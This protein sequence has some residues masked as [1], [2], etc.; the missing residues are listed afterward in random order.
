MAFHWGFSTI[1]GS[2]FLHPVLNCHMSKWMSFFTCFL[3]AFYIPRAATN[4][5]RPA[6]FSPSDSTALYRLLGLPVEKVGSETGVYT[7][8]NGGQSLAARLWLFEHAQTSINIQYYSLTKDV[9]GRLA[10][11]YLVR[12]ADRGVL[13]RIL[14]DDA[15]NRMKNFDMQLLNSHKNIE[16]RVYNAGFKAG[17]IDKKLTRLGKNVDRML[18]RM[19]NKTLT[20][21]GSVC[22]MGGRNIADRY[23]DYDLKYNFRDRDVVFFGKAVREVQHSFDQFWNSKLTVPYEELSS[24]KNKK[25]LA[26][27]ARFNCMHNFPKKMK[28]LAAMITKNAEN[29]PQDVKAWLA[30]DTVVFTPNVTFISDVPGKNEDRDRQGGVCTDS[31]ISLI[32]HARRSLDIQTPYFIITQEARQLI[33]ETTER[34]VKIRLITNSLASTDNLGAFSGYQKNRRAL[35]KMG[36]LIYEFKPDAK[37]KYELMSKEVQGPLNYKPVFGFHP[38][39]LII[40]DRVCVIGSYNFDPRSAN[41]NTECMCVIRS[42]KLAAHLS[43]HF[44]EEFL[45]D[46]SWPFTKEHNPDKKAG[47]RKRLQAAIRWLV[48]KKLL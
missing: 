10:C 8:E 11:H 34:G 31:M 21:D 46:N 14:V 17:R 35:A 12:A 38:K 20:A 23:F 30:A 25:A 2:K 16:I 3:S 33:T 26:D 39:S 48:P 43:Q 15:A 7:L 1:C 5:A 13:I 24:K 32:K 28:D 6:K 4:V 45:L 18:R 29:F 9:S 22:I 44:N 41:Y 42:E 37:V 27:P 19:H 40:D 47:L 36:I